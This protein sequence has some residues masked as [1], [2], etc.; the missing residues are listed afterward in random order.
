M[1]NDVVKMFLDKRKKHLIITGSLASGKSTLFNEIAQQVEITTLKTKYFYE[2][3]YKFLKLAFN[4]DWDNAL[5]I[6]TYN[7]HTKE[8]KVFS[9]VFSNEVILKLDSIETRYIGIDEIGF[10]EDKEEEYTNKIIEL[11]QKKSMIIVLRKDKETSLLKKLRNL[12][13]AYYIDLDLY[14]HNISCIVM[15]SGYSKRFKSNK[16]LSKINDETLIE[17]TLKQIP[18]D[19]FKE[20]IV[21]TRYQQVKEIASNY[22]VICLVHD[23]EYQSDTIKIGLNNISEVSGVMFLTADQPL[24]TKESIVNM[25]Y[26]FR[27][28]PSKILRLTY[29]DIVGNPVIF[30]KKY[31][32]K[33]NRLKRDDGGSLIIKE[34]LSEVIH[35][36][37]TDVGELMDID[38]EDDLKKVKAMLIK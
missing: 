1:I 24:R 32:N 36:N 25:I 23:Y 16:L 21:V 29:K 30:P 7:C 14:R 34:H 15:A 33:L 31:F 27:N 3:D 10:L 8:K 6:P 18:Y 26:S 19:L 12:T 4:D 2:E 9:D 11:L 35:V 22:P 20:V 13:S 17:M 38:T 5:V 28:N 37:A